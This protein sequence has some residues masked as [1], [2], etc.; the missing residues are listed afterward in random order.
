MPF[1]ISALRVLLM[2][3]V[4]AAVPAAAQRSLITIHVGKTGMFS[5]L[6]HNHIITAPV[7][8]ATIDTKAL[9]AEILV[10]SREMKVIDKEVSDSDRAKIQSTMMGPD[11]LDTEK[12]PEIRFKSSKIEQSSPQHYRVNGSLTL[13]GV[14]RPV[15]FEV[16]SDAD[17]YHGTA[18]LN[19]TDFGIKPVSAAGG[20]VKVKDQLELEFDLYAGEFTDRKQ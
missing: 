11:V 14:T 19:Q 2:A 1:R 13:H 4:F 20:T 9:N 18:R 16:S 15:S 6:G 7:S 10:L 12:F 5:G 8:K 17:H 3:L